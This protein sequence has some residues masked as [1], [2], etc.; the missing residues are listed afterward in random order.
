MPD[1]YSM[2]AVT[3]YA[4]IAGWALDELDAIGYHRGAAIDTT[5]KRI[6]E[7]LQICLDGREGLP[8]IKLTM[9]WYS[10]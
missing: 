8:W 2:A 7:D 1:K 4:E 9:D 6:E 5:S 3:Q 10:C